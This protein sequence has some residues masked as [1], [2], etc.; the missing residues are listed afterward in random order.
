M[1]TTSKRSD[2]AKTYVVQALACYDSPSSV[3]DAVKAEF[4]VEVTRQTIEGYDPT[5]HAGKNVAK[6]WRD[7]FETTRKQFLKSTADIP[8]A[9]RSYRPRAIGRM[10]AHAERLKNYALAAQLLEQAAKECGDIFTNRQ[11]V[12]VTLPEYE[13]RLTELESASVRRTR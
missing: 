2:P 8:I 3:A 12:D 1:A 5:K 11:K 13:R 6:N 4:G 7:L 10:A 9:H